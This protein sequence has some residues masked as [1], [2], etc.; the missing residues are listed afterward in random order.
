M[1]DEDDGRHARTVGRALDE[2]GR[3]LPFPRQLHTSVRQGFVRRLL[4]WRKDKSV[5]HSGNLMQFTPIGNVY[6]YFRYDDTD[7]VM[8]V[9]N[10]GNDPATLDMARFEERLGGK[11]FAEDVITG[12]RYGIE[13]TLRIEPRS[14]MVLETDQ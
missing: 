2:D 11:R 7:T 6:A 5:I 14:V 12:K 13:R 8:V 10:R 3:E 9:F 1:I 4:N